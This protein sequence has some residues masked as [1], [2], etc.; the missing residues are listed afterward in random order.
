MLLREATEPAR[1]AAPPADADR[2]AGSA[3]QPEAGHLPCEC[4]GQPARLHILEDYAG[5]QP[6]LRHYCLP[7][8]AH[9]SASISPV[10][11]DKPRPGTIVLVGLAGLT[12]F[13]VGLFADY[14]APGNPGFGWHQRTGLILGL[15]LTGVGVVLRAQLIALLGVFVL[16]ASLTADWIG[17]ARGAGIG[18]KQQAFMY[19]GLLITLASAVLKWIRIRMASARGASST[20]AC[21][22]PGCQRTARLA[23]QGNA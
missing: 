18:W 6:R 17:V 11:H 9:W 14:L 15:S 21:A 16:G 19:V 3:A 5:G 13:L 23:G 4:C 7:C 12:M 2:A 20:A 22:A 10:A 8:G 1:D